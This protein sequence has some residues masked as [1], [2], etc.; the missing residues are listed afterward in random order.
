M[1]TSI[2]CI[3]LLG[4][5]FGHGQNWCLKIPGPAITNWHLLSLPMGQ[6]FGRG[7]YHHATICDDGGAQSSDGPT[8]WQGRRHQNW[9]LF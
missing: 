4:A 9:C 3:V 1:N 6:R 8:L 7:G 5:T 2:L